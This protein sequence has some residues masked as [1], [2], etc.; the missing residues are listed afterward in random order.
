MNILSLQSHVVYGHVGNSAAV[1]AL[2]RLG[3]EVWPLHTVQFSN[4]TA[5]PTSPG[6]AFD[7]A[8]IREL[9]QGLD[10]RGALRKC[11]AALSGYVGSA[12]TGSAILDAAAKTRLANPDALYCCDPVIG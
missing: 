6:C 5:Y 1:F 3:V 11:D 8:H 4:H 2:Q 9:T 10:E 7:A 12:E